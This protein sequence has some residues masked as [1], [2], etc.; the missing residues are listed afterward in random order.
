MPLGRWRSPASRGTTTGSCGGAARAWRGTSAC[1]SSPRPEMELTAPGR[2]NLIGE[3]TDYSG[4]LVLPVA[5]DLGITLTFGQSDVVE[6]DAPGGERIVDAVVAELATRGRPGVGLRGNV[7]ADLP[8]GAGLGSSGAFEVVVALAL[9][10]V[11]GWDLEPLELALACAQAE[12]SATGVPCGILDQAASL[13][14]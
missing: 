1:A 7:S 9:G 11:A 5:I 13:L 2:V 8:Q 4:G 10:E 12:E 3:H 14:G 6:L